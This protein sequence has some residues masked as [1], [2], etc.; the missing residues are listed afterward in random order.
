MNRIKNRHTHIDKFYTPKLLIKQCVIDI[1]N[2]CKNIKYIIDTSCGNNM[3]VKEMNISKYQ[4]F[5]IDPPTDHYGKITKCNFLK[6]KTI[7][8]FPQT[9]IGFNPPFGWRSSIAKQFILKMM[10]LKPKYIALILLEPST[11][12]KWQFSNYKILLEK[13]IFCHVPCRFYILEYLETYDHIQ[14]LLPRKSTKFKITIPNLIINRKKIILPHKD[15]IFVRF[16]GVNAGLE[17]Y[18]LYKKFIF[19]ILFKNFKTKQYDIVLKETFEHKVNTTVF[20][21]IYYPFENLKY[22]QNIIFYLHKY[23]KTVMNLKSLRYN[24]TT[25]DISHLVEK[26]IV[27]YKNKKN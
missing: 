13:P 9:L 15:C 21:K 23:A 27:Q 16:T 19:H 8:I 10:L 20:T 18:I 22:I 25:Y 6:Q 12:C 24:F 5:D 17:Y 14:P 11:T 26:R 1:H 7:D 4:S 3:F 2:V